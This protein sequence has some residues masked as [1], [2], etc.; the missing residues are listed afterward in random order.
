ML[1][2]TLLT[3]DALRKSKIR[4]IS[5]SPA[6]CMG[7]AYVN[8]SSWTGYFRKTRMTP[9]VNPCSG[10]LR[11]LSGR[12][13]LAGVIRR[14]TEKYKGAERKVRFGSVLGWNWIGSGNPGL[15]GSDM[16]IGCSSGTWLYNVT[17]DMD[18]WAEKKRAA[19]AGDKW[20]PPIA[21]VSKWG[22]RAS[23]KREL[24]STVVKPSLSNLAQLE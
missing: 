9:S 12:T 20:P 7:S 8:V 16:M 4:T 18:G 13:P 19:T 5:S 14:G 10:K 3:Y 6:L 24:R 2:S 17:D 22:H 15:H 23:W 11:A 1:R 21:N